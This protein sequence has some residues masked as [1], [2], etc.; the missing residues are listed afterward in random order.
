MLPQANWP[1]Q[2]RRPQTGDCA[3]RRTALCLGSA[4]PLPTSWAVDGNSKGPPSSAGEH[5]AF[6]RQIVGARPAC[7]DL[8][9][10]CGCCA[11]AGRWCT[12][13]TQAVAGITRQRNTQLSSSPCGRSGRPA[14][15]KTEFFQSVGP[16]EP[17]L[18]RPRM[19]PIHGPITMGAA[20]PAT[21]FSNRRQGGIDCRTATVP[22]SQLRADHPL[23]CPCSSDTVEPSHPKR[24][25]HLKDCWL[26]STQT[27]VCA[28]RGRFP[29]GPGNL[30]NLAALGELFPHNFVEDA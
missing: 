13:R 28:L 11:D 14:G 12:L 29:I 2:G 27:G 23:S 16:F 15:D 21:A 3:N 17:V 26:P 6:N 24:G 25:L 1:S 4:P 19:L 22:V 9:T 18:Q 10:F 8:R 5:A 7:R 20:P 30:L